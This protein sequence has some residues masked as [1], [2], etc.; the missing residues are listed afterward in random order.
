MSLTISSEI[1]IARGD[2]QVIVT[3]KLLEDIDL[4]Q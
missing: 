2:S 3:E 1:I 4:M